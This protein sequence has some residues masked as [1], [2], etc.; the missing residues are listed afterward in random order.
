MK[1]MEGLYTANWILLRKINT[2]R[3]NYTVEDSI[4]LRCQVFPNW[5]IDWIQS[6]SKS[7]Q[8]YFWKLE[9]R[10]QNSYE[11][12]K[13]RIIKAVLKNN[14]AEGVPLVDSKTYYKL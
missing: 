9:S 11:V 4:L 3:T 10:F 7:R 14:N 5:F 6:W 1:D 8:F 12:Q 2:L 13:T